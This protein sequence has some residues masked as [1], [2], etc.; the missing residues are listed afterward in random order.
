MTWT[1]YS[2]SDTKGVRHFVTAADPGS[3][4]LIRA[5]V[6]TVVFSLRSAR[7]G[8]TGLHVALVPRTRAPHLDRWAVPGRW[9]EA[10]ADRARAMNAVVD[11]DF[12]FGKY[13][14]LGKPIAA[15]ELNK[16]FV[17][18]LRRY[19]FSIVNPQNPINAWTAI[20]WVADNFWLRITRRETF[21]GPE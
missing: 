7:D 18:L 17:E 3:S 8:A 5:A 14:C 9:L 19:D 2:H 16:I 1:S 10:D 11:L 13:Q 12:G 21:Q 6:S 15:M 4:A 20:F